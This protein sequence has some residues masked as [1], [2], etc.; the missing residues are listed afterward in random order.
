MM[1]HNPA[2][3]TYVRMVAAVTSEAVA[4]FIPSPLLV[5]KNNAERN[6]GGVGV[7][8]SIRELCGG[9]LCIGVPSYLVMVLNRS[10]I[11]F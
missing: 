2:I 8:V 9:G 7:F 1:L 6:L 4:L 3:V 5:M 11:G 10:E